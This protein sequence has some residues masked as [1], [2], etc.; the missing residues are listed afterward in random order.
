MQSSQRPA[1]KSILITSGV[2][3]AGLFLAVL[4][5]RIAPTL[6]AHVAA[7]RA[8]GIAREYLRTHSVRK[9]QIGAGRIDY[10]GWLNTDIDPG[11][12]EAYLDLTKRFPLP[13]E[14]VQY[15]FGEHVI[16]HLNY[17]DGMAM[18]RECYRVL[19]PGGKI[20]FATPNLLKYLQL[21]RDPKTPEID[22]YLNAKLRWHG[23]PQTSDRENMILNMEMRSFGH[24]FLYDPRSLSDRLTQAGFRM[25]AEFPPGES[26]D[27]QVRGVESRHNNAKLRP[28]N[29][30]ETMVIQGVRP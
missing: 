13:D 23:W 8:P 11:P 15:I 22:S 9:L 4:L 24:E 1:W 27:P 14:S 5:V 17:D 6:Q 3:A 25:I 26:D 18:L 20:R 10:P 21:F 29:D 16:E 7:L 19:A 28:M 30:Y 12:D 2:I